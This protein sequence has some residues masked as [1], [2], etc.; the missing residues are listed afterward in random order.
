[1]TPEH[2]AGYRAC[3]DVVARERRY[4]GMVE[5]SAPEVVRE[6]VEG[7]IRKKAAYFV[8][9]ADGEVVGWCA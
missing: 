8:A 4:L 3:L 1:M 7:S 5:A 2:V 6:W 9:V